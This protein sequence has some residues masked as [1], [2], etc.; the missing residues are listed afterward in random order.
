[1]VAVLP[2]AFG[3]PFVVGFVQSLCSLWTKAVEIFLDFGFFEVLAAIGLAA[4]SRTI[5]SRRSLGTGFL[6]ASAAAPA[7]MLVVASG[8]G[9][10]W[11]AVACLATALVNVAVVAQVLQNGEVPRLRL[12][13]S[14]RRR[15][16]NEVK[17]DEG[18]S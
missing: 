17:I 6:I 11:I 12:R 18:S 2:I 16:P 10:R 1:M 3:L 7:A 15:E 13:R 14:M 5:Y 9:Q 8:P 4:V